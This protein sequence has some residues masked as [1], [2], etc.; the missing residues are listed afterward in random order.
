[1]QIPVTYNLR[2]MRVRRVT[3]IMTALGTA[4]SVAVLLCVLA[5]VQGL[6]TSFEG[7]GD[8]QHLLVLRKGATAEL[9]SVVSREGFQVI[10]SK[11]GIEMA[12]LELVTIVDVEDPR[13]EQMNVNLRGLLPVGFEMRPQ[14]HL[15][16]GRFF[17]PGS[18]EAVVGK[19]IADKYKSARMGQK[20][21]IG[22]GE[23]EIVGV[24]DAGR[25]AYNSEIFVD[26]NQLSTD[27]SRTGFL[28]SVLIKPLPGWSNSVRADIEQDRQLNVFVQ[29]ERDYYA[30]QTKS[31]LPVQYMGLLVA[32]IMAIGSAFALMN[33][34]YA[35]VARR[36]A[37][38]GTLRVL[39]F[40]QRQ[41]LQSFLLESLLVAAIGGLLGCL[42]VLP[43]NDFDTRIGSFQT[44]SEMAFSF[45]I[46]PPVLAIGLAFS[47][48]IGVIAGM[49]PAVRAARREILVA[50]RG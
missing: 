7:T 10:R 50:L 14:I 8:A 27:Y 15:M 32:V 36:S 16:A 42:L 3:T 30:A 41:I 37:E 48:S 29:S 39:G 28:S 2:N 44:F 46:T 35:A 13:V 6:R 23:W 26:L 24:V 11:P 33:T 34:M 20:I 45:Q 49:L 43:L 31:S 21:F 9:M 5:L 47:L 1:M 38:V 12:S 18:R 22:R 17:R 40:S 4:L 19:A 25:S